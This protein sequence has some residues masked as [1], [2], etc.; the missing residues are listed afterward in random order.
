MSGV[1]GK[2]TDIVRIDKWL[3]CVRL[4]KTR[5]QATEACRAGKVKW[6]GQ[7]VKPS[8]S[9]LTGDIFQVN[10]GWITKNVS[11]KSLLHNRLPANL[12]P[13]YLEDLTL[14]EEYE[15][16]KLINE[17]KNEYRDRGAGRP[18]KRERREID[19]LKD[20]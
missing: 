10:V 3:W 8:R 4:F 11:V 14:P 12:V 1:T 17:M 18:T 13:E 20:V 6:N 9:V 2:A 16:L 15:K 7:V 5:N 19:R